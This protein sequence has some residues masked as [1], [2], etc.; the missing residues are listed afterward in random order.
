MTNLLFS[1]SFTTI[2][3]TYHTA[4]LKGTVQWSLVYLH[5]CAA[6]QGFPGATSGK[7]TTC[8]CRRL[9][10][11]VQSLGGGETLE[12]GMATHSS[13]L[14]WRIPRIEGPGGLQ[15]TGSQRVRRN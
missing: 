6:I 9:K 5:S 10:M 8:Q 4:H 12:E 7:E 3:L 11:Q 13:I 2:K 14:A 15:G 1:S